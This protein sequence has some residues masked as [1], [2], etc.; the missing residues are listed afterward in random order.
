MGLLPERTL[1]SRC[2][3][4]APRAEA[5]APAQGADL[6]RCP[7]PLD[8]DLPV[9]IQSVRVHR[10]EALVAKRCNSVYEPGLRSGRVDEARERG[11]QFVIGGYT[12][13]TKTFEAPSSDVTRA[14]FSSTPRALE[15]DLRE[16]PLA[17]AAGSAN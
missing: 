5:I 10:F 9:L 4:E 7:A 16:L 6:V 15:T 1:F 8:A 11:Q 2:V 14:I 17:E 3:G 12:I 13:G